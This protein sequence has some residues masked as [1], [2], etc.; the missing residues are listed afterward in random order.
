[1]L[2]KEFDPALRCWNRYDRPLVVLR[3]PDGRTI[4]SVLL[5]E[6]L[7]VEWTPGSDF[8]WCDSGN[9]RQPPVR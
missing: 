3:L 4:G 7:A 5:A 2:R 6:G 8:N 9:V 1:M